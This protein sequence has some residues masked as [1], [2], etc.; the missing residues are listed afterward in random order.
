M[1]PVTVLRS[2]V[3]LKS[4]IVPSR[5]KIAPPNPA[6]RRRC[7]YT[8]LAVLSASVELVMVTVPN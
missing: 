4:V 2:G 3:S 8:P 7:R 5:L 1:P 6:R